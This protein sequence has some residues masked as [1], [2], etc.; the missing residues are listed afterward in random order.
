MTALREGVLE[1]DALRYEVHRVRDSNG[2]A[3]GFAAMPVISMTSRY[4][5]KLSSNNLERSRH[6][7][8]DS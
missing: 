5:S 7:R 6:H 8:E 3:R 2:L 4:D 1:K